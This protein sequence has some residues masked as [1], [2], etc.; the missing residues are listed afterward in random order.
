MN[1]TDNTNT[2]KSITYQN[3]YSDGEFVS[4]MVSDD[5]DPTPGTVT[6]SEKPRYQAELPDQVAE[7]ALKDNTPS[8]FNSEE[9]LTFEL[10]AVSAETTIKTVR[11]YVKDNNSDSYET[12]NLLRE[13]GDVFTKELPSVDLYGK[14]WYDIISRSATGIRQ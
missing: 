13:S 3:G 12:Y 7:P 10:E 4:T 2:D 1:G 8:S 5:S 11:L 9:S 14:A 6:D